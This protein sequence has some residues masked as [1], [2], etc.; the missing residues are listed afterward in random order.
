MGHIQKLAMIGVCCALAACDVSSF[1]SQAYPDRSQH[2]FQ[3]ADGIHVLTY[4]CLNGSNAASAH[5]YVDSGIL[6]AERR[7]AG[8]QQSFGGLG[9]RADVNAEI[10]RIS[11]Q[12]EAEYRCVLINRK[13][14]S[15]RA[16]FG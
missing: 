7:V 2:S 8:N 10:A 13:N 16:L 5:R 9:A 14:T 6:S 4:A 15:E 12:A 11:R 3:S 1:G